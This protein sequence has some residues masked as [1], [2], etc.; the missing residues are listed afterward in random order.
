MPV[1]LSLRSTITGLPGLSGEMEIVHGITG[2]FRRSD[3]LMEKGNVFFPG[4]GREMIGKL[5]RI[6]H[7][8]VEHAINH[9]EVPMPFVR[10]HAQEMDEEVMKKHIGLYVN[11]FTLDPGDLGRRAV[12]KLREVARENRL[13]ES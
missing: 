2:F 7:R 5:N 12:E 10:Q 8:S 1:L 4:L 3:R 13:L 9:P 6:L 11:E